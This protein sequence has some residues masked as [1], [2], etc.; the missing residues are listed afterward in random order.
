MYD[1]PGWYVHPP[2]TVAD[3]ATEDALRRDG[4][5]GPAF[6]PGSAQH[7]GHHQH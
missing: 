4:I 6:A 7:G 2:G 5:Q 3:R 1:D